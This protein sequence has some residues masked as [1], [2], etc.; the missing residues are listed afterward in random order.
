MHT[1]FFD[2]AGRLHL[3]ILGPENWNLAFTALKKGG[4]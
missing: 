3:F 1:T 4:E 2:K